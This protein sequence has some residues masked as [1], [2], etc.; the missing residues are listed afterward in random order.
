MPFIEYPHELAELIADLSGAYG[1]HSEGEECPFNLRKMCRA[2]FVSTI[3]DRIRNSVENE[4][5]RD[6]E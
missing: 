6:S 3:T 1:A 2:C 5:K 4:R